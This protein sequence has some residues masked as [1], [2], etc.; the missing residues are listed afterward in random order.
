[1]TFFDVL[2]QIME[3]ETEAME[4]SIPLSQLVDHLK[5]EGPLFRVRF[6]D[7]T[8]I[9]T[10][11]ST[12]LTTDFTLFLLAS[13]SDTPATRTSAP[14]LYLRMAYNSLLF[15][16]TRIT[17]LLESLLQLLLSAASHESTHPLGSL[18]LRTSQISTLPDPTSDL[19]WCGFVGA[20]P[21]ILSANA[22]AH[23][24]RICVVQSEI[25]EGQT[26]T[27]GPSRGRRSF[28]YQQIDEASNV[29]AHALQK[30]G[31]QREEVV[32]VYAARSVEMIVC[33]MGILKAGGVFSVVGMSG[34]LSIPDCADSLF[35]IPH[36]RQVGNP[37]TSRS[38]HLVLSSSSPV[39]VPSHLPFLTLS[40]P[41]YPSACSFLPS[42][43][44]SPASPALAP[45]LLI[46]SNHSS[47]FHKHRLASSSVPTRRRHSA[48]HLAAQEYRRVSRVDITA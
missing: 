45:D 23:P 17:A 30:N 36:T 47:S 41:T 34:S 1:M 4:D 12:S 37:S 35:K 25:A 33:V 7:S 38:Q 43:S 42:R 19:D 5:P 3:K 26:V 44:P 6:L 39:R 20:I 46:S 9:E 15:T 10:D 18:P 29:V 28:T 2:R 27:D 48:S 24:E 40:P 13:P 16:Q 11:S 32:M 22:K 21:D 14:S 31:L 8:Q